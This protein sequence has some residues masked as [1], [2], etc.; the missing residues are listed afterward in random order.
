MS[1]PLLEDVLSSFVYV[2]E[3]DFLTRGMV[4]GHET[5]GVPSADALHALDRAD[6]AV[7]LDVDGTVLQEVPDDVDDWLRPVDRRQENGV[8]RAPEVVAP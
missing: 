1:E 6:E 3:D 4:A 8:Q 5:I 7:Q 2:R